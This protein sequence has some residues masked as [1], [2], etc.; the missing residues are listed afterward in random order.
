[1]IRATS[2]PDGSIMTLKASVNGPVVYLDNWAFIE[3]AKKD[4]S[5]RRRFLDAIRSGADVLFSVTNAAELSGPQGRSAE[6]VK[7]FLDEIG[8][9]WYPAKLDPMEA[10]KLEIRREDP[11]KV[12]FDEQFF[13]TYVADRIRSYDKRVFALTDEFFSLAT[14]MDRLGPQQKSISETSAKFDQMLKNKMSAVRK[15][16]KRDPSLLDKKFPWIPF[17]PARPACFV[18]FNLLR[19]MA[20]ESNSLTKGDGLDFCHAVTGCAYANFTTLDIAWKRRI[21]NLPKP[22]GLACV[23]SRA[24]LNQMVADIEAVVAGPTRVGVLVLNESIRKNL[25]GSNAPCRLIMKDFESWNSR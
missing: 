13:K 7:A 14:M 15:M 16:S 3:L 10:V 22:N 21:A 20:L 19:I 25:T 6:A 5:R 23:Y 18:F 9:R 11:G 12:C 1:M 24:E 8:P 4:P 2:R 17:D